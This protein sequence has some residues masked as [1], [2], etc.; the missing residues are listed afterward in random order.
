MKFLCNEKREQI[1]EKIEKDNNEITL[2]NIDIQ[3]LRSF[4]RIFFRLR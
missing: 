3:C 2:Y 4:K 1:I